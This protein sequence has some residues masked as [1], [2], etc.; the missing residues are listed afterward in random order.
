MLMC[1]ILFTLKLCIEF[2]TYRIY[3]VI[4]NKI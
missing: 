3:F 1:L 2:I 4:E